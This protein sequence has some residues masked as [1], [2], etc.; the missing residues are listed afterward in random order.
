VWKELRTLGINLRRRRNG[1]VSTDPE[2]ATRSTDLVGL[3][4][5]PPGNAR[6]LAVGESPG[7]LP[8]EEER[9]RLE[10]PDGASLGDLSLEY[11]RR[12]TADLV[13]ALEV[14]T[15][16]VAAG[17]FPRKREDEFLRFLDTVV[18]HTRASS[19]SSAS[20]SRAL[21]FPVTSILGGRGTLRC[22]STSRTTTAPW[23][24]PIELWFRILSSRAASP[25]SSG[26]A[27]EL[28]RAFGAF[29]EVYSENV[30]VP[31][32][33]WACGGELRAD[34]RNG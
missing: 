15:D 31:W 5:G 33:R 16:Q 7:S 26:S 24:H 4:L 2:F 9:G 27:G 34:A 11:H 10:M 22:I 6:V 3:Y 23:L 17:R 29:V 30:A 1:S 19:C 13:A 21:T 28:V 8:P 20:T 32:R 14:A 18:A 25:E 12:S